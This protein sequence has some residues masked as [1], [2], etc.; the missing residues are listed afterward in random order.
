VLFKRSIGQAT[1]AFRQLVAKI[2]QI[3]R[4]DSF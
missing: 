2:V 1:V 3:G 4:L